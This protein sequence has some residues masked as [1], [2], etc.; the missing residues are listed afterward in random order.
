MAA[1]RPWF[2]IPAS[3]ASWLLGALMAAPFIGLAAVVALWA[4]DARTDVIIGKGGA[5]LVFFLFAVYI[6]IAIAAGVWLP[7]LLQWQAGG[8]PPQRVAFTATFAA[9]F[10]VFIL[11]IAK[12]PVS[13]GSAAYVVLTLLQWLSIAVMPGVVLHI[14]SAKEPAPGPRSAPRPTEA[15]ERGAASPARPAR[16]RAY[17]DPPAAPGAV[18]SEPSSRGVRAR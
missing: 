2:A 6:P 5:G 3:I 18:G 12:S 1:N 16:R 11:K 14:T 13:T 9:V 10:G 4:F 15:G 7:I 8:A 17:S